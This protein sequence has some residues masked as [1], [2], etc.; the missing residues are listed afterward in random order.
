MKKSSVSMKG[1]SEDTNHYIMSMFSKFQGV[2]S[3]PL[4]KY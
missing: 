2:I 3:L 4:F 1:D